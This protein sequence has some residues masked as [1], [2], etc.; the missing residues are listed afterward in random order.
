[1]C[2]TNTLTIAGIE[3]VQSKN[4]RNTG[5]PEHRNTGT[6]EYRNTGIPEHKN[7]GT[8]EHRNTGPVNVQPAVIPHHYLILYHSLTGVIPHLYFFLKA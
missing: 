2:K 6:R 5:T 1:M 3:Y 4:H 8:Q 7:T